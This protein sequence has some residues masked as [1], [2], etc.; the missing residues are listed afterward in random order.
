VT[1]ERDCCSS[2]NAKCG[3]TAY[4]W[5]ATDGAGD[6]CGEKRKTR[7]TTA[8]ASCGGTNS[9]S[10]YHT[11]NNK[12]CCSS[13]NAVCDWTAYSW[14]E[15]D[16]AGDSCGSYRKTRTTKTGESCGGTNS[17]SGYDTKKNQG[18]LL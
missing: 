7:T 11:K 2:V 1:H 12:D 6:G 13:V 8:Q 9:C 3:W 4:S 18:L 15:T 10:G 5:T 16:G 14:T 17:C